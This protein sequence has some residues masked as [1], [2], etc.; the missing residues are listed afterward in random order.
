[1]AFDRE[2]VG[3]SWEGDGGHRREPGERKSAGRERG[4][5]SVHPGSTEEWLAGCREGGTGICY[6]KY[7]CYRK[8]KH[9]S[10]SE[11]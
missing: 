8:A 6:A 4:Q 7:Y 1:M 9:F 5:I 2:G 3:L 11:N 10:V